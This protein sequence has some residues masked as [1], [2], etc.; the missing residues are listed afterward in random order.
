MVDNVDD[1]RAAFSKEIS[2][3]KK[4]ISRLGKSVSSRASDAAEQAEELYAEGKQRGAHAVRQV[5]E[6][7]LAT[8]E[9]MRE[10]PGTTATVLASVGILGLAAGMILGGALSSRR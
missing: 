4:E 5:K 7:A 3:M 1:I 6:Q 9:V 2:D 8:A 10:N